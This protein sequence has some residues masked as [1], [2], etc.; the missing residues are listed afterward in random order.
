[1]TERRMTNEERVLNQELELYKALQKSP[2]LF[3]KIMWGLEPQAGEF[4]R[5][6]NITWQQME[7]L[8][9]VEKALRGE[10]P[11]RITIKSGHG[12]GKSS[13]LAWLILWYLFCYK[14]AQIPCTAPT[15]DQMYDV[16][17]KEVK[18]WLNEM[19]EEV[20][21]KYE[22]STTY[23]RIK[24]SPETWFARAKTARKESP[25]ALA[26]V[27]GDYVMFLVDEASGVPEEI[28]NTAEG[29]L[30]NK[31]VLLIMISNPTRLMGYFYDSHHRDKAN[32]QCLSFSSIDSPIVDKEFVDRIVDKHGE[33][34]DEYKLRVLGEFPREDAIDEKGFV[35]LFAEDDLHYCQ[36][37]EWIGVT[38]MGVDPSGEG[39]DKTAWVGRDNIKARILAEEAI[40]NP[41]GIAQKTMTLMDYNGIRDKDVMVDNFGSGADVAKDIALSVLRYDV[42]TINVGNPPKDEMYLNK[43]AEAYF[44][45]KTWLRNGGSLVQDSRWR[46]LLG[47]KFKRNIAGKIQIM[48]KDEMRKQ[49]IPSPNFAD[50]L[51][52]TFID[53]PRMTYKA[54]QF[55]PKNLKR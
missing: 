11:N 3:V 18:K 41:K 17:W 14:D 19:P 13:T 40:S 28:F 36:P 52:L 37:S 6:K 47:I 12:I 25:E 54:K 16:L 50:A 31:N 10:A 9:A 21:A 29:A 42:G 44:A 51:M 26:G 48:S 32:W 24:E 2:T 35:P 39:Q 46:E 30:T 38:K 20:A 55:Y 53:N 4:I 43:R 34:S 22:W 5:G 1:M 49:G 27:H 45:L 23:I 7:I 15:A 8:N 33:D